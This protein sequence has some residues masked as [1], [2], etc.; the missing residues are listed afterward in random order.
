MGALWTDTPKDHLWVAI[1]DDR[2][3]TLVKGLFERHESGAAAGHKYL[4]QHIQ[5]PW[6]V[7]D[8]QWVADIWNNPD[9]FSATQGRV[10]ERCWDLAPQE[11]AS[12]SDPAAVWVPVNDGTWMLADLDGGTLLLY[13]VRTVIGGAIPDEAATTWAMTT[14]DDML[15]HVVSRAVDIPGHYDSLHVPF[16]RPDGQAIPPVLRLPQ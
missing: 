6:P 1:L 8:R 3:D 10:W 15:E 14:L 5:L 7:N 16:E 2:H 12:E 4:Y 13:Q 9:L 11:S